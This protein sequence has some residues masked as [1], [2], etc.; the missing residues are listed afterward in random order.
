MEPESAST[1]YWEEIMGKDLM[2][3]RI[4]NG[5]GELAEMG[6]VVTCNFTGFMVNGGEV[7]KEPFEHWENQKFKVG[8]SDAIPGIEMGLRFSHPG[9][10]MKVRCNS[11][12]AYGPVGRPS[13]S[14]SRTDT[15]NH[16]LSSGSNSSPATKVA[17]QIVAIPPNTDLEYEIVVLSHLPEGEV[18]PELSASHPFTFTPHNG[19]AEEEEVEDEQEDP[20][21]A[22]DAAKMRHRQ[23]LLSLA[24][25]LL[26][27]EAGN[28]WFSYSDYARAARCY[29]KG[30][31]AA[32]RYFN[33]KPSPAEAAAAAAA[34]GA[35]GSQGAIQN[36]ANS[37]AGAVAGQDLE[38]QASN[39]ATAEAALAAEAAEKEKRQRMF[40]ASDNELVAIFVS[41]LNNMSACQL[42][43]GDFAK[44]KE[45]CI[46][47]L[48][49]EPN[50]Q[51]A[52]LRAAK[53]ALGTHV[54]YVVS[55]DSV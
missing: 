48:E 30:T 13:V 46:R 9:D 24:E 1:P 19:S 41:C 52:L 7:E 5:S 49:I 27:K 11:K 39:I 10:V 12:F 26:R 51:K 16:A 22:L 6:T 2:I 25:L 23:R 55:L 32:D 53:A 54:R 29:S 3:H 38:T 20:E 33:G 15:D 43:L 34:G 37:D 28:R 18:D 21:V 35:G 40:D 31:Q 50:N 17:D 45:V 47:V 42:L 44:A 36:L 8:E 14:R 4:V